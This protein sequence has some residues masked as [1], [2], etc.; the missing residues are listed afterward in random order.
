MVH[1]TCF[2]APPLRAASGEPASNL[3]P[4][5]FW[6]IAFITMLPALG[7]TMDIQ[8]T[9]MAGQWPV[10]ASPLVLKSDSSAKEEILVL[11]RGGQL[12]L[13]VARRVDGNTMGGVDDAG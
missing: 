1:Q 11:N 10:E 2:H 3:N 5:L 13:C 7:W 8:W 9:R 6:V 4:R 12:L